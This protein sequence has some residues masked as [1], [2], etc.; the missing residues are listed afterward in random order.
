MDYPFLMRIP[1]PCVY[2]VVDGQYGNRLTELPQG[3]P[4]WIVDTPANRA[5]AE[6]L[7]AEFPDRTYLNGVTL[8][9]ATAACAEERV[10]N[11]LETVDLHHGSYSADPA[12]AGIEIVGAE[13]TARLTAELSLYG[14]T[15]IAVTDSGFRA[16][17]P[18]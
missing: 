16:S 18:L 7:W 4:V 13:P 11:E 5:V 14:L 10:I 8:F 17:R 1:P 3:Q 9:S 15:D 2:V 12:Y 6:K